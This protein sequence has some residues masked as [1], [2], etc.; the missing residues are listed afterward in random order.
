MR[1]HR[2]F[3]TLLAARF[4]VPL[5]LWGS[6]AAGV[7]DNL[8]SEVVYSAVIGRFWAAGADPAAF[9]V[10]LGGTLGWADFA[11]TLHPL[12][13]LYAAFPPVW[14]YALTEAALLV[15]AYAGFRLLLGALGLQ[16][17]AVLACLAAFGLSYSSYGAGLAGAPLLLALLFRAAPLRGWEWGIVG[18][19]GLNSAFALHGLFLPLAALALA[20]M[21]GRWP[22]A[23]RAAGILALYL[24]ASLAASAGLVLSVLSGVPSHRAD[25]VPVLSAT[26]LADWATGTL[27][28][29]A[30][31]GSA[32]HAVITPA[33]HVPVVVLAALWCGLRRAAL[34]LAGLVALA[35]AVQLA[36]P[37]AAARL[38]AL[39]SIQWHRFLLFAPMLALVLAAMVPG[40]AVRVALALALGQ[41]VLAGI[42]IGPAALK[43]AVPPDRV[44]AIR[45]TLKAE[46]RMAALQQA[47]A[48]LAALRPADLARGV[49][50]WN[51][52]TRPDSYACLRAAL[53]ADGARRVLSH[54]PDPMLAPLHGIPAIDGYHNHYPL[55]WKRAF[56]PVIAARLAADPALAAYYDGWGSRIGTLAD[57]GA[58]GV[59]P[60]WAAAAR[61]GATHVIADRAV[62][63][64]APVADCA[65]LRLYRIAP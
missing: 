14:A 39:G 27:A 33:L 9:S 2:L 54:G 42:G 6:I 55:A 13:L 53:A 59:D 3:L 65:D 12:G 19:L 44:A 60:D 5:I 30:T 45:A 11:R 37:M 28:N 49:E 62:P 58:A 31:L 52:H 10:F 34:V 23:G 50:T 4:A 57:R 38:G 36:E 47:G 64:L 43:G 40:R 21:A 22:G 24:A 1:A 41:A 25:W 46:G 17:G 48:A 16:G 51:R 35:V 56:R 18:L 20:A 61:L 7:H 63:G 29:L 32:Y 8:D 15:L 26:P